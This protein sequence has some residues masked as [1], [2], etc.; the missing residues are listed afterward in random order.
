MLVM[1][2]SGP[3]AA[4]IGVSLALAATSG[5]ADAADRPASTPGWRVVQNLGSNGSA[6]DISA[7][8]QSN[9]WAT[10]ITGPPNS[11]SLFVERWNGRAWHMITVPKRFTG[12][13]FP[14]LV[15][16]SVSGPS[17][18]SAFVVVTLS[19]N[20]GAAYSQYGLIWNGHSWSTTKLASIPG[21]DGVA[22][23]SGSDMWVF[24]TAS[25]PYALRYNGRAWR[26]TPL[27]AY[28]RGG[29]LT[30][31][32]A[33]DIWL[34]GSADNPLGRPRPEVPVAMH[35][36]GKA[37][38]TLRL[39]KVRAPHGGIATLVGGTIG[40][41]PSE[42]M[43]VAVFPPPCC[44]GGLAKPGIVVVRWNGK[45][46]RVLGEDRQD[47]VNGPIVADGHGGMWI[48]GLGDK[49]VTTPSVVH[50]SAGK[51]ARQVLRVG[52]D[53][54]ELYAMYLIPG[55]RSV[56]AA[57]ATSAAGLILRYVI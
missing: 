9:A 54:A 41:G 14:V 5:W 25:H 33:S 40:L 29:N 2:R 23:F 35:W 10:G 26:R 49:N 7:T 56:W 11:E 27:P 13:P 43:A 20:G 50:Y 18:K 1:R 17:A 37:W 30:A 44:A 39:P 48:A 4:L 45:S 8:A 22:A 21:P 16:A 46:W 47:L 51:F 52:G 34:A 53:S 24:E 12:L 55:T 6:T 42:L 28:P 31:L 57:G 32:S 19:S 3:F 36:N 15:T 38:R